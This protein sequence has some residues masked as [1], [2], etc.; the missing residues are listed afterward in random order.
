MSAQLSSKPVSRNHQ[1][2][3]VPSLFKKSSTI[4]PAADQFLVA[5]TDATLLVG[6]LASCKLS[7]IPWSPNSLGPGL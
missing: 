5:H 3:I 1:I 7:E 6:D 2:N 4:S